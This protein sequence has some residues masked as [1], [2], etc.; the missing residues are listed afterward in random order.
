M[1]RMYDTGERL[2]LTY[3]LSRRGKKMP[4]SSPRDLN[5]GIHRSGEGGGG[6]AHYMAAA[7]KGGRATNSW[8]TI[9]GG[10]GKI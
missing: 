9:A 8:I 1:A 3:I 2:L 4:N 7:R 10:V 6:G 5:G